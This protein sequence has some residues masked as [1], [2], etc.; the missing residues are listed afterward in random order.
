MPEQPEHE[1][2][3]DLTDPTDVG[4]HDTFEDLFEEVELDP[5]QQPH[6]DATKI[7]ES[8][9]LESV[10]LTPDG[11]APRGTVKVE[12]KPGTRWVC[13]GQGC[14]AVWTTDP[15]PHHTHEIPVPGSKSRV[16]YENHKITK[17]EG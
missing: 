7:V 8:M 1:W 4:D 5:D 15:G 9:D 12:E 3:E 16:T 14:G 13:S 10:D 11:F 17:V 6:P 2:R